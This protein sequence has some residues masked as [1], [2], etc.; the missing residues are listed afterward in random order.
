MELLGNIVGYAGVDYGERKCRAALVDD[1]GVLID[2]FSFSNDSD[3]WNDRVD[4]RVLAFLQGELVAECYVHLRDIREIRAFVRHRI[5][6]L[7][8]NTLIGL[9]IYVNASVDEDVSCCST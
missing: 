2:E 6:L 1:G 9:I 8:L 7:G 4:A 5:G 3:N